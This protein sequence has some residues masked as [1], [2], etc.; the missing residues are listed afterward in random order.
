MKVT[1]I[2]GSPRKGSSYKAAQLFKDEMLKNGEI[3]FTEFFL[4]KDLPEFCHGCMACFT[5]GRDKCPHAQYTLPIL[6]SM[7]KAD[8]LIFTSPVFVMQT[9]G[10]MK[11]FLDHFGHIFLV[12]RAE[13][14]MFNKKAYILS[15]TAGAGTKA[16]IKTIKTSVKFWGVNRVYSSGFALHEVDWQ[17]MK[18]KRKHKFEAKINKEA[19]KFYKEV[20][21]GKKRRPYLM[22]RIMFSFMRGMIKKYDNSSLD[23]QYWQEK[24]WFN[25]TPFK[26]KK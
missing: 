19:S 6:D 15:T 14:S 25:T 22:T 2:Y 24:N 17:N 12:H 21:S 20:E 11:N 5:Y 8:A 23:K 26:R 1:I 3:E 4:P 9:S 7:L 13:E 16:A 10:A 18:P